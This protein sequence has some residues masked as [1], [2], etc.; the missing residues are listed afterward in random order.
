VIQRAVSPV[1]LHTVCRDSEIVSQTTH[2]DPTLNR[3]G[4]ELLDGV[5]EIVD[6]QGDRR[7]P[8]YADLAALPPA[9]LLS[10]HA[11]G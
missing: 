8:L 6:A 11:G 1:L 3:S 10:E 9:P 4:I 2:D 5:V 7:S